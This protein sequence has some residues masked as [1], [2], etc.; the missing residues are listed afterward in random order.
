VRFFRRVRYSLYKD[1]DNQ[2]YLGYSDCL[3]G[4]APACSA[5]R[6]LSGPYRPYQAGPTSTTGI[7][8][9]YYDTTGAT[10][11]TP[12]NVARIELSLRA[13]GKLAANAATSSGLSFTDS[14]M[15]VIGLRNRR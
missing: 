11:A 3:T 5:V 13:K 6:P 15:V 8:F 4:R 12:A 1:T 14:L 9:A 2:W 7:R 10:T